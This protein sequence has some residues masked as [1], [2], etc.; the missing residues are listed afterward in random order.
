MQFVMLLISNGN[1]QI[2]VVCFNQ[3]MFILN[4]KKFNIILLKIF[5]K[6]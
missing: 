3:I 5:N 2:Q 4:E 6:F 1:Q